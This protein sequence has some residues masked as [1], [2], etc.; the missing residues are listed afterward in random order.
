MSLHETMRYIR[1]L[2]LALVALVLIV[3][4][5]ANRGAVSVNLLPAGLADF[6]GGPVVVAMPLYLVIL[7]AGVAGLALGFLWEWLREHKYRAAARRERRNAGRLGREVEKL[8]GT[9]DQRDEVVA[10]LEDRETRR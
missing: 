3:V 7:G 10:L 5:S 4:A 8:R 6:L 2:F 1:L 9:P